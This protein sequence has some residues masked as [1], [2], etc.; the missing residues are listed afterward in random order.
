MSTLACLFD[1]HDYHYEVHIYDDVH[2]DNKSELIEVHVACYRCDLTWFYTFD[3]GYTH[4]DN[5]S[6][7]DR[8]TLPKDIPRPLRGLRRLIKKA[9]EKQK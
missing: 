5:K 8:I 7:L 1:L 9:K 3:K 2:V 4:S 6:I